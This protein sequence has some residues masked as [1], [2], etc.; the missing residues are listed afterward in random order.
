MAA[1]IAIRL[2]FC[3]R[4]TADIYTAVDIPILRIYSIPGTG[5]ISIVED[6]PIHLIFSTRGMANIFTRADIPILR[7]FCIL[8]T[9]GI[10]IADDIPILPT[11]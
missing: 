9:A 2:T 5:S 10:F 8:L 6:I 7:I 1:G 3:I 4:G 11:S